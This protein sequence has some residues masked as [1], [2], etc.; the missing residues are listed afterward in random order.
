MVEDMIGM[1]EKEARSRADSARAMF[2]ASV[3]RH[4]VDVADKPSGERKVT[5]SWRHEHGREDEVLARIGRLNDLIVCCGDRAILMML[6]TPMTLNAAIFES[7]RPVLVVPP[8]AGTA[9]IR[10]RVG[11]FVEWQCAICH[12]QF[13]LR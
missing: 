13:L 7:G 5:V 8:G 9:S 3:I 10:K 1:A 11:D 2:D 12:A 6:L 4:G